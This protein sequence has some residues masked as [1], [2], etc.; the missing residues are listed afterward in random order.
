MAVGLR[1]TSALFFVEVMTTTINQANNPEKL[2][3]LVKDV[4]FWTNEAHKTLAKYKFTEKRVK[5]MYSQLA[6]VIREYGVRY[7][8][9][10]VCLGLIAACTLVSDIWYKY[11]QAGVYKKEWIELEGALDDLYCFYDPKLEEK[12]LIR[13]GEEMAAEFEK[14]ISRM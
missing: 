13:L 5:K 12:E 3:N 2:I 11:R 6:A 10:P 4:E 1:Q 14:I 8:G 9:L 7:D